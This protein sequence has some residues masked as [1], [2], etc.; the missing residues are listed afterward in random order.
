VKDGSAFCNAAMDFGAVSLK[1]TTE[2]SDGWAGAS[3]PTISITLV[4]LSQ[5]A[6]TDFLKSS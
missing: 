2:C 1:A 4:R 6:K 5:I 3:S